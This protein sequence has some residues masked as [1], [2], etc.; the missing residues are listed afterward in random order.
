MKIT[1]SAVSKLI[2][3]HRAASG[4]TGAVAMPGGVAARSAASISQRLLGLARP[5]TSAR[6][7]GHDQREVEQHVQRQRQPDHRRRHRAT[8]RRRCAAGRRRR[9]AG[10]RSRSRTSRP[11]WRPSRRRSCRRAATAAGAA[12]RCGCQPARRYSHQPIQLVASISTPMPTMRRKAKNSG[13]TG[14]WS[15]PKLRRPLISPSASWVRIRLASFG[16][17]DLEVVALRWLRRGSR[18]AA[19]AR[20]ARSPRRLPSR[21]SWPAGAR[22]V[23]RPCRSPTKICTGISTAASVSP[24]RSTRGAERCATP[25]STCQAARPASRKAQVSAD[26]SIMCVKRYG[27]D[28]LKITS[29]QLDD[30]EP[31]RRG[32]RGRSASASTSSAPGSRTPTAWCRRRR[33]RSRAGAPAR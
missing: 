3:V 11:P 28:G 24:T 29:S 12:A 23:F 8:R 15:A 27:N 9:R 6:D 31:R 5:C 1:G 19:A 13:S 22:S 2:A 7:I 30:V 14:G 17:A 4:T 25:C 33:R 26:A 20:R 18:T 16:I 21:R 32:S 10:G